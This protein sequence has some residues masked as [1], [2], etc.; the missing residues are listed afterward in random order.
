MP[1]HPR[2]I[3]IRRQV[4]HPRGHEVQDHTASRDARP[5]ELRQLCTKGIVNVIDE[6]GGL[7]GGVGVCGNVQQVGTVCMGRLREQGQHGV[8]VTR[9]VSNPSFPLNC[10][11]STLMHIRCKSCDHRFG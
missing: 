2:I 6:P 1:Y 4:A 10:C 9:H 7:H 5:V 11:F 8:R 3:H